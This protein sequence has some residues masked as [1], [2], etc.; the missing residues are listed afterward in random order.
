M[1]ATAQDFV[2]PDT[3]G[4]EHRLSDLT[5]DGPVV[6]VF[7]CNHCPQA[8]AW[9][10]R[11][12]DVARDYAP[13]DVAMVFVNP[14][15]DGRHQADSL[16]AMRERVAAEDWPGPYLRDESQEVAREFG[17]QVTP[18]VFVVDADMRVRYRGA[19]DP[20]VDD[21]AANALWLRE[22][23]DDVL[24]GVEL[25]RPETE[26]AGCPITWKP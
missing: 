24:Y 19:P 13:R 8:R 9:H 23:L 14:N 16:E 21:P 1:T 26:P 2:L 5:D 4:R 3:E 15:D 25:R 22:A 6:V 10:Q 7:T 17:A 12:V 11:L 18:D 20:D